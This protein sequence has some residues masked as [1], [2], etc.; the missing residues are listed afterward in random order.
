[1]L[2]LLIV[3]YIIQYY[4][5]I[6]ATGNI[7]IVKKKIMYMDRIWAGLRVRVMSII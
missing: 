5:K 1:M 6:E 3:K 2:M 7:V 4:M